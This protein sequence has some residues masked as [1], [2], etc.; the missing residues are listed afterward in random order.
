MDGEKLDRILERSSSRSQR[1]TWFG[2]LLAKESG[3][4][5]QL[6]IVGGSAIEVY[7]DGAYVSSDVDLVGKKEHIRPVL[8]AWGFQE[9]LGRDHRRYW[10]RPSVGLV[11]LVGPALKSGLPGLTLRT[12]HGAVRLAAVEDLI[13][14][15]LMRSGREHSPALFRQAVTLAERFRASLDWRYMEALS[16]S[17]RILGLYRQFLQRGDEAG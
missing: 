10:Y 11:D 6:A 13:V 17:E 9:R 5:D 3:A 2:A 15:R 7:T 14:H 8:R 4:G 16:R 1:L 12:R